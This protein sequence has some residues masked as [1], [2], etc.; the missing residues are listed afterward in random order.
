MSTSLLYRATPDLN[1]PKQ[2]TVAKSSSRRTILRTAS[3]CRQHARVCFCDCCR[4]KRAPSCVWF[5]YE[6]EDER[7]LS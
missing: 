6:A 7:G 3:T 5:A 4:N 2:V 1:E